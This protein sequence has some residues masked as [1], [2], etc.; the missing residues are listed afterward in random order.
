MRRELLIRAATPVRVLETSCLDCPFQ[1]VIHSAD[2]DSQVI[3]G[4]N[5]ELENTLYQVLKC[6]GC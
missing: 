3:L 2:T 1:K 4:R 5:T 6:E